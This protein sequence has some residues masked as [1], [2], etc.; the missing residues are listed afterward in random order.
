MVSRR[1]MSRI[2][3][4][5]KRKKLLGVGFGTTVIDLWKLETAKIGSG[6]GNEHL[7]RICTCK[8][9]CESII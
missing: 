7:E 6:L 9:T 4:I 3:S 2:F 8:C 5:N 1:G